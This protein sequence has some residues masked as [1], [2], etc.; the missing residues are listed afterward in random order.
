MKNEDVCSLKSSSLVGA[1]Y[2]SLKTEEQQCP[3]TKVNQQLRNAATIS[4]IN[5][6]H[7]IDFA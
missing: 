7:P 2:S 3:Q 5:T 4:T 1:S 6:K